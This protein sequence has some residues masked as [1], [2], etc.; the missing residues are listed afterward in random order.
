MTLFKINSIIFVIFSVG[1]FDMFSVFHMWIKMGLWDLQITESCFYLHLHCIPIPR[2]Q[3]QF[4]TISL[5]LWVQSLAS[6]GM[7]CSMSLKKMRKLEKWITKEGPGLIKLLSTEDKQYLKV[8]IL[9]N[10]AKKKPTKI[11]HR[12][13]E[14]HLE[15]QFNH[16]LF[17]EP[18]L[19]LV[20]VEDKKPFSW[21]ATGNRGWGV[22]N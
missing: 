17:A 6:P 19:E 3:T 8:T 21:R 7:V 12:T 4:V 22:L 18:S 2:E 5:V 10:G 13:S 16:Q 20:S 9:G 14:T 1:T 15:L 11:W